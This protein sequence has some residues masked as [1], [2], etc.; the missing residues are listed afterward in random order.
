MGE[1]RSRDPRAPAEADFEALLER[2]ARALDTADLIDATGALGELAQLLPDDPTNAPLLGRA[3]WLASL[4]SLGQ[5]RL[6]DFVATS[7]DAIATLE[8]AGNSR[9]AADARAARGEIL[10][11]L[12][13]SIDVQARGAIGYL[14][15]VDAHVS[16]LL[17]AAAGR[18]S[19]AAVDR[20]RLQLEDLART[21]ADAAGRALP[22]VRLAAGLALDPLELTAV[23]VLVGLANRPQL[24]A[25]AHRLLGEADDAPGFRARDVAELGLQRE[26]ARASLVDRLADRG[27]LVRSRV[28][29]VVAGG[30]PD[31]RRVAVGSDLLWF[32]RD[33]PL[34]ELPR[35]P[36]LDAWVAAAGDVALMAPLRPASARVAAALGAARA[37]VIALVGSRGAGKA[38][39]ALAAAATAGR[40]L[41]VVDP[42]HAGSAGA[43]EAVAIGVRDARLHGAAL[44]V[45]L[46]RGPAPI[47]AAVDQ[48]AV[49][50][51]LAI[52]AAD[53]VDAL[54]ELRRRRADLA[55]IEVPSLPLSEQVRLWTQGATTLAM[56][57]LDPAQVESFLVRP[58]LLAGDV[59][60]SLVAAVAASATGAEPTVRAIAGQLE[61]R[62]TAELAAA[63]ALITPGV[64]V[65]SPALAAAV[66]AVAATVR[67][68]AVDVDAWG[69]GAR[70]SDR[71]AHVAVALAG[72]AVAHAPSIARALA[73]ALEA[74]LV[75]LDA[76]ELPDDA[77]AR[78]GALASLAGR[79]NAVVWI[80]HA[81][82]AGGRAARAVAAGMALGSSTWLV[83]PAPGAALPLGIADAAQVRIDGEEPT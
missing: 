54:A 29:D 8:A 12:E 62:L 17:E 6:D 58:G 70:Q 9:A 82:A 57:A 49:P 41:L 69:L 10:G 31:D 63:A 52:D 5:G 81:D 74:P 3:L 43:A 64:P 18:A 2:A 77:A 42:E 71:P 16:L 4:V 72:D 50:L 35:P 66:D 55:V 59:A 25:E 46:D 28:V 44:L 37:P 60:D 14:D 79:A 53:A 11:R 26:D 73:A 48:P 68:G 78:V 76:R 83:S 23:L 56:P 19:W 36:G 75:R 38:T 24:A 30:P 33:L 34:V 65:L 61:Q 45:R 67:A 13:R 21:P 32:L 7:D 39:V 47:A 20:D 51:I 22:I 40:P 15:A 80:D 27:R 1:P